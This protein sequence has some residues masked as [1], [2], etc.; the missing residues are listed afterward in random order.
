MTLPNWMPKEKEIPS[1][2]MGE[3]SNC[4]YILRKE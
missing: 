4:K 3:L 1:G 2:T